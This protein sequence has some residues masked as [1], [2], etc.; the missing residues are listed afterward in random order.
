MDSKRNV[1]DY[2]SK[3]R[4]TPIMAKHF[5]CISCNKHVF[6]PPITTMDGRKLKCGRCSSV[7][8]DYKTRLYGLEKL[9]S[10]MEFPCEVDLCDAI[11]PWGKVT[12]HERV[13]SYRTI[14]CPMGNCDEYPMNTITSHFKRYH[15]HYFKCVNECYLKTTF[16]AHLKLI[17]F[18]GKPYLIFSYINNDD[19]WVSVYAAGAS[20]D[21][22]FQVTFQDKKTERVMIFKGG[23]PVHFQEEEHCLGCL[24][25][26]CNLLTHK[27][28]LAYS[29]HSA[30]FDDMMVRINT[31]LLVKVFGSKLVNCKVKITESDSAEQDDQHNYR[32]ISKM[33]VC[34]SCDQPL[35]APIYSCETGHS[36][37]AFCKEK[38]THC[39]SCEHQLTDLRCLPLEAIAQ[40]IHLFCCNR[41]HGCSFVGNRNERI[42]HENVCIARPVMSQN[43]VNNQPLYIV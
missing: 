30:V 39:P 29:N 43:E 18:K 1:L 9:A 41:E 5:K 2:I 37:C 32:E 12:D 40:S 34:P 24:G 36:I 16:G 15:K 38:L 42:A 35:S 13:C 22:S 26:K 28:S 31:Q 4:L 8:T 19:I 14:V 27:K 11:V 3:V 17:L 7:N 21:V 25:R 20:T 6:V 10:Y 33:L 23:K